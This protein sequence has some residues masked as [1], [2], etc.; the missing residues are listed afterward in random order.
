MKENWSIALI[1]MEW[2][3]WKV[4]L[5]FRSKYKQAK[6]KNKRKYKIDNLRHKWRLTLIC[7]S[8]QKSYF[9]EDSR[10]KYKKCFVD[11]FWQTVTAREVNII[12]SVKTFSLLMSIYTSLTWVTG[13]V[14]HILNSSYK[15]RSVDVKE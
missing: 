6:Y 4:D 13:W 10:W 14:H 3:I 2:K 15:R 5:L 9:L 12:K 8:Q 11:Q 1:N 7:F